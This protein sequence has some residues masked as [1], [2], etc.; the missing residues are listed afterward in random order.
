M[1]VGNTDFLPLLR[2][3]IEQAGV[4]GQLFVAAAGNDCHN[5]D[6]ADRRAYPASLDL[7]NIISVAATDHRDGLAPFSNFGANRVHLGAPG[8]N[9]FSTL[10]VRSTP[11][12]DLKR[13]SAGY[14]AI[15]GTSMA[16]PHVAGVAALLKAS[17]PTANAA[18]LKQRILDNVDAI[19]S[20]AGKVLTG[21][22]LNAEAALNGTTG[23]SRIA[24]KTWRPTESAASRNNIINPGESW[25]F[26]VYAENRGTEMAFGVTGVLSTGSPFITVTQASS[27]FGNLGPKESRQGSADYS[28][29]VSPATPTPHSAELVFTF[30]DSFGQERQSRVMVTVQTVST[31]SGSVTDAATGLPVAGASVYAMGPRDFGPVRTGPSGAYTLPL[32]DGSS[33]VTAKAGGYFDATES[34]TAPAGPG[35]PLITRHFPL[36]WVVPAVVPASLAAVVSGAGTATQQ[37]SITAIGC[38]PLAWTVW[39]NAT[40]YSVESSVDAGGPVFVWNDISTT[41]TAIPAGQWALSLPLGFSFP[42]YG[43]Q[44]EEIHISPHG[45]ATLTPEANLYLSQEDNTALPTENTPR[46][47][48]EMIAWLWDAFQPDQTSAVRFAYPDRTTFVIQYTG[49]PFRASPGRKLTCQAV[50]KADGTILFHYLTVRVTDHG[51]VG[52]Q[53]ATRTKGVRAAFNQSYLRDNF[54][55]RFRPLGVAPWLNLSPGSATTAAG[56]LSTVSATFNATGLPVGTY[57]AKIILDSNSPSLPRLLVP[58]A[59]TTTADVP[60]PEPP[61]WVKASDAGEFSDRVRVTWGASTGATAYDVQRRTHPFGSLT[62]VATSTTGTTFDD[63]AAAPGQTYAYQVI[64]RNA[65]GTSAASEFEVGIA[66]AGLDA[67]RLGVHPFGKISYSGGQVSAIRI[68]WYENLPDLPGGSRLEFSADGGEEFTTLAEWSSGGPTYFVHTGY[69][70]QPGGAYLYRF[71]PDAA[72]SFA[73]DQFIIIP[74]PATGPVP[75]QAVESYAWAAG[76]FGMENMGNDALVGDEADPDGDGISNLMEYAIG[77]PPTVPG[78]SWLPKVA[79]EMDPRANFNMTSNYPPGPAL[80]L[81]LYPTLEVSKNPGAINLNYIVEF[82]TDL[83]EWNSGEGITTAIYDQPDRMKVRSVIPIGAVPT[84]FLRLKVSH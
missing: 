77:S 54:S 74:G 25:G 14:G 42:F 63:L 41:G 84:Q 62:T 28:I 72:S 80:N 71:S 49:M 39:S 31:I 16:C 66:G 44:Y 50:L 12:M 35:N 6:S 37:F 52:I 26:R 69:P 67:A 75:G 8:V 33:A 15:S 68:N 81:P 3:E 9:V 22:R 57:H 58:V 21:G 43:R 7:P 78:T 2:S 55:V 46:S 61:Q 19:P 38:A 82:S 47:N 29:A 4:A 27:S 59:L 73:V 56:A 20:L 83:Q 40:E 18:V 34:V 64:A 24:F 11:S 30:T 65:S 79:I 51:T 53:D 60:I 45:Y 70:F 48:S 1:S 36:R 13:L 76:A 23:S 17:N 32:V 10:P 5:N